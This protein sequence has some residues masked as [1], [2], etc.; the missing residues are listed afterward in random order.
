M[1]SKKSLDKK[2][3]NEI[4]KIYREVGNGVVIDIF[5][6]TK[7]FNV[8]KQAHAEGRDMRAAMAAFIQTIRRN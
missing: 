3:E 8:A 4:S 5:D 7:V 1:A 2:L 6:I